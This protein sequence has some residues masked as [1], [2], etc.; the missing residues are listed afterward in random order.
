MTWKSKRTAHETA[1]RKA[2]EDA[3]PAIRAF[4]RGLCL[5]RMS[6][7]DLVQSACERAISRAEQVTDLSGVKSWLNR[8]IYTQWQDTLRRRQRNV[9]KIKE[10]YLYRESSEDYSSRN[11]ER[12]RTARLDLEKAL[13]K[14]SP[15]FRAVT[16]LVI[17]LGYN[18]Q[19]TALI[20]EVP[21]GTVASR[22]ARAR[23]KMAELLS[24]DNQKRKKVSLNAE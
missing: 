16:V 10:L 8:I 2:M 1:V 9:R 4:A 6:A 22:V 15:D 18:H 12:A 20:L 17:M 21:A 5:D 11:V 23:G 24:V 19:E 14:L 13:S 7:D 3:L